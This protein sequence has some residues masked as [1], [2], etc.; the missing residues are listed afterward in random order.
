MNNLIRLCTYIRRELAARPD[1]EHVQAYLRTLMSIPHLLYVV[2]IYRYADPT[3]AFNLASL[4][5]V[6]SSL[7][8]GGLAFLGHIIVFP[9]TNYVRRWVGIVYDMSII[10]LTIF[11]LGD[12][13]APVFV[14]YIWVVIGNG[15]RYGI[16]FLYGAAA[17]ALLSFYIV[18]YFSPFYRS[19]VGLLVLATV[20]LG[21]VIPVYLGGLLKK[22]QQNLLA[23]READRLKTR[24]LSNV[25]HDL[26]T[27][28][29]A[30]MA[31]C[32]LLA[33]ELGDNSRQSRRIY[34]MQ[35]AATTLNN[36]LGDLLDVAR[37]EA[38]RIKIMSSRF[39]LIEL[40][41]R[42]TRFNRTGA[43]TNQTEIYL[44][45][46]PGTPPY[47]FGD[48]L[49]LEQVLNNIVSNAV[50]YTDNG[51][52][53]IYAKPDI[54]SDTEAYKGIVISVSDTGIGMD[55]E[56]L[57]RIFSRFEQAD[58][59]YA[60]RYS[61][62]GLG[63][64]IANELTVLMGGSIEVKSTKGEGSCFTLTLPVPSA[65]YGPEENM[66]VSY[67]KSVVIVCANEERRLYWNKS[68]ACRDFGNVGIFAVQ[69]LAAGLDSVEPS[70]PD[71]AFV[72]V[73][74]C[75]LKTPIDEVPALAGAFLRRP[76]AP[77]V[78]V[79][80]SCGSRDAPTE[81]KN[82]CCWTAQDN[83]ENVFNALAVAYWTMGSESSKS[84]CD[85]ELR[86]W[87][88]ALRGLTILVADDNKLNRR[89]L[90]DMLACADARVVEAANGAD[91]FAILS[92]GR[93]DIG[94]L[95][96]Q[97]PEMTGIEVMRAQR[98]RTSESPIPTVALTADT[99][100]ECRIKCLDAGARCILYKP[101][102]MKTLY[103][104]LA[105]IVTAVDFTPTARQ[106]LCE[107]A[108]AEQELIDYDL[109][110]ELAE[111]GRR[112]DYIEALVACFEEEGNQLLGGLR[113]AF[114]VNQIV[115]SRSLLHRLKGMCS[116]IGARRMAAVCQDSLELSDTELN[117]SAN[118]IT[119][120]LNQLHTD[121]TL[122]LGK[123]SSSP[124][125]SN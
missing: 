62:A 56:A 86:S 96:I 4:I 3:D 82:Y 72:V 23:A 32:D 83:L 22:L 93:I 31:N 33:R 45:V 13:G 40:L 73:D 68:L 63:L 25:S 52:V 113:H 116:S 46:A 77:S 88:T 9:E 85:E 17:L 53:R 64:N 121:S 24:F 61:G 55:A 19:D 1:T 91:A 112:P 99:T 118:T 57:D 21:L 110:R 2:S 84:D 71:P 18:A 65:G 59:A 90:Y 6:S 92:E 105:L 35:E 98:H 69:D 10:G 11:S 42:V 115:E 94:L 114:S 66:F 103:R 7:L 28:L 102:D 30:I 15:F 79:N 51:Q 78:L 124:A 43:R 107:A 41:G 95:D 67:D 125:T 81:Y 29:N 49:R 34:D 38:G 109:L 26:R 106:P 27:P 123:F 5:L 101:V 54:E 122:M 74:A 44:T 100:E 117:A 47:V 37:I 20:L 58:L 80:A 120:T 87:M 16:P 48:A 60:R 108:G 39:N 89:V 36:L 119:A 8:F 76:L 75:E 111:T 12:S 70:R 50:K 14:M 104:E 97:M